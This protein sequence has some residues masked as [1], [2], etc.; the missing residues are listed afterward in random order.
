MF[1]YLPKIAA[2]HDLQA[3]DEHIAKAMTPN[4]AKS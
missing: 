1:G 4:F 3:T 2:N